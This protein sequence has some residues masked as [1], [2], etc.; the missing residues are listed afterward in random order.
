MPQSKTN[1]PLSSIKPEEY[2][3]L[4]REAVGALKFNWRKANAKDDWTKGG[5][6]SEAWDRSTG[7]PYWKKPTYD[8]DYGMRVV[9]KIAQEVPAWRE[10][11]G[12]TAGKLVDRWPLYA[13]WFDWVEETGLDP[14]VGRYPYFYYKHMI[15]PGFAGVYNAPG[16]MGNGLNTAIAE[17][18]ASIFAGSRMKPIAEHPYYPQ[19]APA[20][21][22]EPMVGRRINHDPIYGNGSSNMNYKGYFAHSILQAYVMTGDQRFREPY[23]LVYDDKIRYTYSVEQVVDT[24]CTQHLGDVDENGSPLIYGID[25]EVGKMFPVCVSVGGLAAHLHDK[26]FGT[27]YRAGYDRWLVWAKDNITGGQTEPEGPFAWCAGYY[28]RDIP[29]CMSEPEQQLGLF[30]TFPALQI[31]PVDPEYAT[32]IYESGMKNMG[33]E[34]DNGL[35]MKWPDEVVT[36]LVVDDRIGTAGALA[37][38]H[39]LNDTERLAGL[40]QWYE[41]QCEPTYKDGEFYFGFNAGE[42]WPRGIP[43]AWATLSYIGDAGSFRRLYN[44]VNLEKFEQPTVEGVDYPNLA[45]RQAFYDAEADVLV[46]GTTPGVGR[47]GGATTFRVKNLALTTSHE[48]I[49]DGHPH[50]DYLETGPGQITVRTTIDDHTF[51]IR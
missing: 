1:R 43:N 32:R 15:P 36:P 31:S 21:A 47:R 5:S 50:T 34:D 38:A 46:F 42:S 23:E 17:L 12:Q 9:A 45:V 2:P 44:E 3:T 49:I 4:S 18:P 33:Y 30:Y 10:I 20:V 41:S 8:S 19:H 11:V 39:E 51:V 28:D 22:A 7:W 37:L 27:K 13:S 40:R 29:Y 16:Y 48:V 24:M 6:L 25:C 26:L 35:R 14:N